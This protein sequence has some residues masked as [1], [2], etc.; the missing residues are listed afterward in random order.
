MVSVSR[1]LSRIN[2]VGWVRWQS[3][4][5]SGEQVARVGA[6]RAGGARNSVGYN[7]HNRAF[8]P[9]IKC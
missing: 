7:A 2:A 5:V 9:Q 3:T 6:L 4:D 1:L 8:P